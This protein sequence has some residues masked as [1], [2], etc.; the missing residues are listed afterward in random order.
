[1]LQYD[2]WRCIDL[3]LNDINPFVRIAY[4][5]KWTEQMS[6][7]TYAY[8]C[9]FYYIHTGGGELFVDGKKYNARNGKVFYIPMGSTY[10]FV[11]S[12]GAYLYAIYFDFTNEYSHLK[13]PI[14]GTERPEYTLPEKFTKVIWSRTWRLFE[15]IKRCMDEFSSLAPYYREYT[16]GILKTSLAELIREYELD[17]SDEF[18]IASKALLFARHNAK[19]P[20]LS[21]EDISKHVGYH[22]YYISN[23]VKKATGCTLRQYLTNIRLKKAKNLLCSTNLDITTIAT[24]CGFNSTA[25]F[26]RTF[27]TNI[28]ITPGE[29]RK[30]H[31]LL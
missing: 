10:K 16:S 31:M 24:D 23:L 21:N 27:K 12:E 5:F 17:K 7:P 26:T 28:G 9:R 18:H 13:E 15:S 11:L 8:D 29:Y 22:P 20:N 4:E 30:T 1:M 25:Y 6:K 14:L 19:N 2:L 3:N